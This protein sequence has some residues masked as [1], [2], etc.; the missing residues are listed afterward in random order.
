MPTYSAI[1]KAAAPI[2]GGINWPLTP[3]AA[4]DGA[5]LHR[6][7]ADALHQRNG[8]GAGGDGV[9][10]RG[11]GDHAGQAGGD[12]AGL[13]R[14]A[15]EGA[16]HGE[17]ELDEIISGAGL[18]QQAAEQHEQEHHAGGDAERDAEDALRGEPHLRGGARQR[19]GLVAEHA[20]QPGADEN[21]ERASGWRSPASAGPTARR[22]ASTRQHDADDRNDD[23]RQRRQAGP[24]RDL[25]VEDE[26]VHRRDQRRGAARIQS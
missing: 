15:A 13:G 20:R 8:E 2:T 3:A 25:L 18:L 16:E 4:F 5:G 17:G 22:A 9:G 12:D 23:I 21:V 1:R 11:A 14:P 24:Q 26:Q 19:D 6:R 7:I 10:D